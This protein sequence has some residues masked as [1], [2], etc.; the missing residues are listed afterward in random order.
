MQD[1]T[2]RRTPVP[3]TQFGDPVL[4][5]RAREVDLAEID[6]P[7]VQDIIEDMVAS[8]AAA[9]GAGL[10]A[11]Q[12]SVSKRIVI[13][14]YPAMNRV[15]YGEIEEMPLLVLVNPEIV[16]ASEETRRAPEACLSINTADGG[17]YEGVLERP[18]RVRVRAYDRTG[19]EFTLEAGKFLSRALQHEVD[20][21]EGILFTDRIR[22][23]KDLRIYRPVSASDP[24]LQANVHLASQP[25]AL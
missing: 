10:A 1:D 2:A 12:I 23:L 20:H 21:L 17:R 5:L 16:Y 18:E 3:I 24:V 6:S 15:G 13:I 9:G 22:D 4:R 14:K 25:V 8:L 19:K 7:K 11:P